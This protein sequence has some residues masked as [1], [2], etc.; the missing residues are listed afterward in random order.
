MDADMYRLTGKRVFCA[1]WF[2]IGLLAASHHL[3]EVACSA[4][5]TLPIACLV[6]D[7][8]VTAFLVHVAGL[9]LLYGAT[10]SMGSPF[11]TSVGVIVMM[12]VASYLLF[13]VLGP[14]QDRRNENPNDASST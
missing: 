10:S 9:S 14:R 4:L 2:S 5:L 8:N 3:S 7:Q 12:V 6:S 11:S 13:G 1:Y